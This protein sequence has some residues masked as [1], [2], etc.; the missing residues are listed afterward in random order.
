MKTLISTV[1]LALALG[2]SGPVLAGDVSTAAN[3][4]DCEKAGGTWDANTN[5]CSEKKM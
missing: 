5:K 4:A 2:F 1:A 3:A